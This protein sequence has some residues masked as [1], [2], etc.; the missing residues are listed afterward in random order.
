MWHFDA[1]G[2]KCPTYTIL[3]NMTFIRKHLTVCVSYN[4]HRFLVSLTKYAHYT[5]NIRSI[6]YPG[7]NR[8]FVICILSPIR[9]QSELILCERNQILHAETIYTFVNIHLNSSRK[10]NPFEIN[11]HISCSFPLIIVNFVSIFSNVL[12]VIPTICG[13]IEWFLPE[14]AILK[15]D[16]PCFQKIFS[17]ATCCFENTEWNVL[18]YEVVKT[19]SYW[20]KRKNFMKNFTWATVNTINENCVQGSE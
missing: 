2:N 19:N 11:V 18:L 14:W 7:F 9:A 12:T 6:E 15:C 20:R 5:V 3:V 13:L 17:K 4:N 10:V 8:S 1:L 16:Y